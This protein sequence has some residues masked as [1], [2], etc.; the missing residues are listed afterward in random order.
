MKSLILLLALLIPASVTANTLSVEPKDTKP[1]L[2]DSLSATFA[3][4]KI[5][6]LKRKKAQMNPICTCLLNKQKT[7]WRSYLVISIKMAKSTR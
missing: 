7:V 5:A 2:I 1:A 4:D 6:M 3:I